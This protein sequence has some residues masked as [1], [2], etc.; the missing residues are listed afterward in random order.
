M[1]VDPRRGE[2]ARDRLDPDFEP[3]QTE[4]LWP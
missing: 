3:T 2:Y 1:D 4:K